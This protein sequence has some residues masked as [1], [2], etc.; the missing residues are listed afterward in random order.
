ME[1]VAIVG[2]GP[3]GL[4]LAME[5]RRLGFAPIVFD[6]LAAGQNTSRAVVVQ[7]RTMEVLEAADVTPRLIEQ[8]IVIHSFHIRDRDRVLAEIDLSTIAKET[9]YPFAL[10]IPQDRT[11]AILAARLEELGGSVTRSAEVVAVRPAAGSVQ[12]DI[13]Q[14]EARTTLEAAWVIACDGGHS[15]AREAAQIPFEGG[16][17]EEAFVLADVDLTWSIPREE[18]TLLLAP[19]GLV[20]VVPLPG[21]S[22]RFRIVAT[23]EGDVPPNPP[24]ELFETIL[25]ERG[26][27]NA[28]PHISALHWSSRFHVHHRIAQRLRSGRI[29]LAGDAAH[30]HSP[31][32]GQGMNTG[33]Q[34][35]VTLAEALATTLRSGD[36]FALAAWQAKRH[37]VA[38]DVVSLTDTM[39]RVAT[40]PSRPLQIARDAL[41]SLVGHIPAAQHAM[42]KR[43]SELVYR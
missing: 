26:P 20:V 10:A 11:E 38:Q 40:T 25:A 15:I 5:L 2:A 43:L 4:S 14:G 7:A 19:A 30:I 18:P 28:A 6:R 16:E 24:A 33:I 21:S 22:Q 23:Y 31:A 39:T 3:T 1:Q 42:A 8:G 35:A 12:L 13:Q 41:I 34:D 29:L 27:T 32:G 36:E 37:A 9:K 17:Y